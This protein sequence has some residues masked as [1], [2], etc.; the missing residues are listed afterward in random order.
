LFL[1]FFVSVNVFLHRDDGR[2]NTSPETN[3]SHLSSGS[4]A[5]KSIEHWQDEFNQ[6]SSEPGKRKF[7]IRTKHKAADTINISLLVS[8]FVRPVFPEIE[9]T[10]L[11]QA[12][13]FGRVITNLSLRGPPFLC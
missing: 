5:T 13:L 8:T 4:S 7:K 12:F 3:F 11:P 9:Y 1:A 10:F 6:K 2:F